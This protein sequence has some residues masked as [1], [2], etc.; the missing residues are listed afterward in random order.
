[1]KQQQEI[2]NTIEHLSEVILEL[3]ENTKKLAKAIDIHTEILRKDGKRINSIS[4][5]L[6]NIE[7]KI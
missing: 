4:E 1:M 2:L 7:F 5:R 6:K 3:Y